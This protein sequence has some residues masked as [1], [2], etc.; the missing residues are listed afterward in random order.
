MHSTKKITIGSFIFI[1]YILFRYFSKNDFFS[2]SMK[3]ISFI[4]LSLIIINIVQI[5][6]ENNLLKSNLFGII[7]AS[8]F[9]VSGLSQFIVVI[10]DSNKI[11]KNTIVLVLS[12]IVILNFSLVALVGYK[13]VKLA[14]YENHKTKKYGIILIIYALS[15]MCSLIFI[16]L[17]NI[18]G[19][20][21]IINWFLSIIL[22]I[23]FL[24]FTKHSKDTMKTNNNIK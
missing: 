1:F 14:T 17:V 16:R 7:I 4:G 8:V 15:Y 11:L 22:P 13:L 20:F 9:C 18:G 24:L 3:L 5:L 19:V 23:T 2:A 12:I 10:L 21:L 6:K